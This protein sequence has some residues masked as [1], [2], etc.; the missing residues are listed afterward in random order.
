MVLTTSQPILRC[1]VE[2]QGKLETPVGTIEYDILKG[3]ITW[4]GVEYYDN[5]RYNEK[6]YKAHPERNNWYISKKDDGW[7]FSKPDPTTPRKHLRWGWS[8]PGITGYR[9]AMQV[10]GPKVAQL[11]AFSIDRAYKEDEKTRRERVEYLIKT[12][13]DIKNWF[14]Y[15]TKHQ[16]WHDLVQ[17]LGF[18]HTQSFFN[19]NSANMIKEY[20]L[21]KA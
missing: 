5:Y 18:K 6:I 13:P 15:L 9:L 14:V 4:D 10:L 17:E 1:S 12:N 21:A 11:P 3:D 7:Y 2:K 16:R 8:I 19:P 20:Y